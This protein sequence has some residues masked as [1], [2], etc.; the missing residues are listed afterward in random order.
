MESNKF[1]SKYIGN[2][3]V[4]L[5]SETPYSENQF[6]TKLQAK[7]DKSDQCFEQQEEELI[8]FKEIQH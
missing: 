8:Q 2:K 1:L 5:N 6:Y 7:F 3:L 4:P